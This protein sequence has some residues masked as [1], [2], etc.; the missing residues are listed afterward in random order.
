MTTRCGSNLL[1]SLLQLAGDQLEEDE[2][3]EEQEDEESAI[4]DG[5]SGLGIAVQPSQGA[6][7]RQQ[8]R[9][10][11]LGILCVVIIIC[12]IFQQEYLLIHPSTPQIHHHKPTARPRVPGKHV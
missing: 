6:L 5:D 8:E 4:S 1:R 10:E 7:Q 9:Y 2:R 11:S 12:I 3:E